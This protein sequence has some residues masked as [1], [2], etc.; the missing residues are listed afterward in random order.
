[1][2]KRHWWVEDRGVVT[3]C[4]VGGEQRR[5]GG[6]GSGGGGRGMNRA[7]RCG[8]CALGV[9]RVPCTAG[10]ARRR[11]DPSLRYWWRTSVKK[12]CLA[13]PALSLFSCL[14]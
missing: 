4:V 2:G 7:G 14:D 5:E 10:V 1:M 9:V 6:G 3:W 8:W 11:R 12:C 13:L